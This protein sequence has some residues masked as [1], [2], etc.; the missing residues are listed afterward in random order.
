[1]K[2]SSL[3]SQ[4]SLSLKNR[5][6]SLCSSNLQK[7]RAWFTLVELII[8]ITILAILGLVAFLMMS[9]ATVSAR[10]SNRLASI[11]N[12][13]DASQLQAVQQ[14]ILPLPDQAITLTVSGSDIGW[15][16]YMSWYIAQAYGYSDSVYDPQDRTPYIYRLGQARDKSQ[17][18]AYLENGGSIS[19]GDIL[20]AQ[21]HFFPFFPSL[22]SAQAADFSKRVPYV[23]GDRLGIVLSNTT[24]E[25]ANALI[26][27]QNTNTGTLD[28]GGN[29]IDTNYS[30]YV[31]ESLKLSSV[32]GT[33][34][35]ALKTNDGLDD[36]LAGATIVASNGSNTGSSS[37]ACGLTQIEV[38]AMN[39]PFEAANSYTMTET[40]WCDT[41]NLNIT[42]QPV[43][44]TALWGIMKLVNLTD[45]ILE[46]TGISSIPSSIGNLT[47]LSYLNVNANDLATLPSSIGSL[48]NLTSLL[49]AW[50]ANL[51]TLPDTIWNLN[52]I[53]QLDLDGTNL[54]NLVGA[55]Q[56][57]STN[58]SVTQTNITTT[59]Q[60]IHIIT[61]DDNYV[62]II[63]W[64]IPP[65]SCG[66]TEQE[67]IDLNAIGIGEQNDQHTGQEWCNITD[68]DW[69]YKWLTELPA[70]LAK[71][72]WVT[73]LNLNANNFDGVDLSSWW[74]WSLSGLTWLNL[75]QNTLTSVPTGIENLSDLE[76][77]DLSGNQ[78][79]TIPPGI[80]TLTQLQ[81]L[82]FDLN[83]INEPI[84]SNIG[85]LTNLT[86]F[87]FDDNQVPSLPDE[88]GYLT[89]LSNL[90]F[91]NN[92]IAALPET[93]SGLTN[94]EVLTAFGNDIANLPTDI[95]NMSSLQRIDIGEN[96]IL[97]IPDS[98][99][100]LSSL[101]EFYIND[102]L[103]TS[104]PETF[105]NLTSLAWFSAA[106]NNLS[107][108]PDTIGNL[109][110]QLAEFRLLGNSGLGNL[111]YNFGKWGS[112]NRTGN[113]ITS[114]SRN[115]QIQEPNDSNWHLSIYVTP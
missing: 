5:D 36:L 2:Y 115:V 107:T 17:Y 4:L 85:N 33:W 24:N 32:E 71:I 75:A 62:E 73:V 81:T 21:S 60:E 41:T 67:I 91:A 1:M 50:N 10:D 99:G 98:I 47:N 43:N 28:L 12:I 89:L 79:S 95:G 57:F 113:N 52:T 23:Y 20:V 30:I 6:N 86:N 70:G 29:T 22:D 72:P 38:D 53:E 68:I 114:A 104:L 87:E 40:E 7:I 25:P 105:G 3:F 109:H 27:D 8:V 58:S 37:N 18:L 96:A 39:I 46:D 54:G 19:Q 78:I 14:R 112:A 94:L 15:Q 111:N 34:A 101:N 26:Y 102:N 82:N 100:N 13:Y 31:N 90:S 77:L 88:I 110:N 44:A 51:S 93:M 35:T 80:W 106:N 97:S 63:V 49:I 108:L 69:S 74:S 59:G 64:A 55:Y 66:L 103:L 84:P 9:D 83:N 48:T 56:S 45:L 11:K 65:P 42:S 16:G 76:F 92:A 61:H